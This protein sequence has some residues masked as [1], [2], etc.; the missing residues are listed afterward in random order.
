M[1]LAG[2]G[3]MLR[4]FQILN[5][6]DLG[7]TTEHVVLGQTQLMTSGAGPGAID[8]LLS[9]VSATAPHGAGRGRGWCRGNALG[10]VRA[11]DR[12]LHRRPA[13]ATGRPSQKRRAVVSSGYF[14]TLKIPMRRP[15]FPTTRIRRITR[16]SI[17]NDTL[18]RIAFSNESR[19]GMHQS[20]TSDWME[21]VG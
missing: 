5:R 4:S 10:R 14:E 9:G 2:A 12:L 17:I 18:A 7:F 13:K 6:V 8:C 16:E 19:S 11:A 20:Q 1:L 3:L 21:I 15:R